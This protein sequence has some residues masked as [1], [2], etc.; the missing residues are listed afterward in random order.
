VV[1]SPPSLDSGRELLVIDDDTEAREALAEFLE[2]SG[3]VVM[4]AANGREALDCLRKSVRL[5]AVIILDLMMP[6]MDGWEFLERQSRDPVLHDIPVVVL[7][8]TPPR[9]LLLA[10]AV[11]LKPVEPEFLLEI[12][13]RL[14]PA[15]I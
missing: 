9:D 10:K 11:L 4:V 15:K 3:Y 8:A 2:H 12:V 1:T 6:V 13:E 7:T 5:P 14:L